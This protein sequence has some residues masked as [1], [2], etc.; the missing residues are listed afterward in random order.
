MAD[1]LNWRLGC[2]AGS[3]GRTFGAS[4]ISVW[5]CLSHIIMYFS[6]AVAVEF[7]RG[8]YSEGFKSFRQG[9]VTVNELAI[10]V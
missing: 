9:P 4:I 10:D 7:G 5:V 8:A 3:A 1:G 2:T 6:C